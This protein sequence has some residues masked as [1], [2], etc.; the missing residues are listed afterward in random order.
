MSTNTKS[1]LKTIMFDPEPNG[2]QQADT[3]VVIVL[4][5]AGTRLAESPSLRLV[6][7]DL[8]ENFI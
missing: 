4:R 1:T 3:S 6:S 8:L 2:V 5:Q 7:L